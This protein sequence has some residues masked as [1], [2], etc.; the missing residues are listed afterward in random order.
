MQHAADPEA[1]KFYRSVLHA[2]NGAGVPF[3]VGGAWALNACA[4]MQRD[5]HDLDLFVRRCDLE[6]VG[7]A[8]SSAGHR[9]E[10]TY[11]HWLAKVRDNGRYIDII[12][13]SG[14]GVAR[15]DDLWL[16]HATEIEL[17]G[18]PVKV[19]PVEEM[20]WSKAFIM[21]RERFDGADVAHFI[22]AVGPRLDWARLARRFGSHWRVLLAHLVLFGFIFPAE[23][24]LVPAWLLDELLERLRR[25]THSPPPRERICG[26]TLLSREQYLADVERDG[27]R[28]AR[29]VPQGGM[30][31]S[32]IEI[33]TR[34]VPS[35]NAPQ[36][37][38]R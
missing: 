15:V 34:A 19:P 38:P 31:E 18:V 35:R 12:F 14:N 5:T 8:L 25:E 30:S 37:S 4:G 1:Q 32:D 10:M 3:M 16:W 9:V 28:D 17:L 20:I 7:D 23:R 26:G 21:E 27:W 22:H 29:L 6:H 24:D 36:P 33:W 2:L 11:P 13:N